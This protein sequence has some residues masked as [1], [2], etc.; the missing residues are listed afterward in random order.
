[1]REKLEA[2][3]VPF[4]LILNL[5]LEDESVELC[6]EKNV[7]VEHLN[8]LNFDFNLHNLEYMTKHS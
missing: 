6:D 8:K 7:I 3:Q 5:F 4:P 1:M 2:K